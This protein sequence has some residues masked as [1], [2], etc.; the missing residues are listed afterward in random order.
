MGRIVVWHCS[1][2]I[3]NSATQAAADKIYRGIKFINLTLQFRNMAKKWH[4]YRHITANTTLLKPF[5]KI[6]LFTLTLITGDVK[7]TPS[8]IAH[9]TCCSLGHKQMIS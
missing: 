5:F 1:K 8:F 6:S 7:V 3:F 2:N 4:F 9:S